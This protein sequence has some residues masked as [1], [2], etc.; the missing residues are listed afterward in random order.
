MDKR[1]KIAHLLRRFGLGAGKHELDFYDRLGFDSAVDRLIDYDNVDEEFPYTFPEFMI[2]KNGN[3]AVDS[4]RPAI[5]WALR[6]VLTQRPLQEKL[7][8]FWHDHFAVSGTKVEFGPVM[9]QYQEVLRFHAAGNFRQLLGAVA[10]TPAMMLYLDNNLNAK[11][12]PNENFS[13]ELMELF[14][15]GSG[16]TEQDVKQVARAFTGWIV[17]FAVAES[18]GQHIYD[19]IKD[20]ILQNRPVTAF[21]VFPEIHDT[22]EKTILGKTGTFDGAQVLDMLV[23]KEE[24]GRNITKKLWECFAYENPEPKLHDRL[25][26]AYFDSK[27]EIRKILRTIV[28]S[29][30]FWSEKCVRR[31]VKS[32]VDFV[33]PIARAIDFRKFALAMR[34][35]KMPLLAPAND[36][37]MGIGYGVFTSMTN[38]GMQLMFPPNVG[39]WEWGDKW[40]NSATMAER[41]QIGDLFFGDEKD[42]RLTGFL[43][44]WIVSEESP[45]NAEECVQVLAKVFDA[46]IPPEKMKILQSACEQHGGVE[47]LKDPKKACIMLKAVCKLLFGAPEYQFC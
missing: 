32:P 7:T 9:H 34:P 23:E 31:K 43:S 28:E 24:T 1:Q 35:P 37:G 3:V 38:Q 15:M 41:M 36:I 42:P 29:D 10:R 44:N 18:N 46:Q 11:T 22:G 39:G 47:A 20:C 6:F 17:A 27:Y 16:Y 33:V 45:K 13:R 5:W 12:K 8:L 21:A 26:K 40:I 30:E 25:T 4:Y 14:T 19:Q 2:E